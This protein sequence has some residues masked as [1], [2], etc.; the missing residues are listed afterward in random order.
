MANVNP[1]Y[2]GWATFTGTSGSTQ[3]RFA[4]CNLAAKQDIN[5]PDLITGHWNRQAYNYG[6][7]D[8]SG[9]ISGPVGEL[10][11][12]AGTGM[13]AMAT[14]RDSCGQLN[15]GS[16]Q[17]HYY[18]SP[19]VGDNTF[20]YGAA[21]VNSITFSC[22][23][24]DVAQFSMDMI[25]AQSADREDISGTFETPEKLIT[26]D[27]VGLKVTPG[28]ISG[29]DQQVFDS[30]YFS[31]FEVT[32]GNNVEAVYALGQP[33]LYP[34]ALV[35]GITTITGSVSAYN[36]PEMFGAYNWDAYEAA[37]TGTVQFNVGPDIIVNL[38][39]QWHRVEPTASVGPII[40][41]V[42]FT[43]VTTQPT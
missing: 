34:F 16:L 33:N 36:I 32:F 21:K 5:A 20:T 19:G 40:S 18:C 29:P 6:K 37:G 25:G 3:F 12:T 22:A 24:G 35:D 13:W 8:I 26:W 41:T 23:A 38:N 9:S 2:M 17:I 11:G 4:D 43:G 28:T 42:A 14:A 39:V 10:F 15:Q 31:N 7:V 30:P 1:G 27:K